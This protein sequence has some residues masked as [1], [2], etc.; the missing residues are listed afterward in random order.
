MLYIAKTSS[1]RE[2]LVA[3]ICITEKTTIK[4]TV[5][6]SKENSP[7]PVVISINQNENPADTARALNR[8][9]DS[10]NLNRIDKRYKTALC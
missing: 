8:G 10:S 6:A 2:T 3:K 7:N 5:N 4:N 9:E 1:N